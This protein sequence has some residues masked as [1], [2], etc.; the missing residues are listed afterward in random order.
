MTNMCFSY[1]FT[2]HPQFLVYSS[3]KPWNF[4]SGKNNGSIFYYNIWSLVLSC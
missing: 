4:L 1:V 3:Q 2:F